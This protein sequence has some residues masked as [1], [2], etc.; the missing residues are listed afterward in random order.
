MLTHLA[1][2]DSHSVCQSRCYQIWL[3]VMFTPCANVGVHKSG[4]LRFPLGVQHRSATTC[5]G[6]S[7][8][9]IFEPQ[10]GRGGC[11]R[12]RS[13]WRGERAG[14]ESGGTFP[15][16]AASSRPD[17][18]Q[19][20]PTHVDMTRHEGIG[21]ARAGCRGAARES[22]VAGEEKGSATQVAAPVLSGAHP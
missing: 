3:S 5:L 16:R 1:L 12:K 19:P 15:F 22:G 7:G 10:R 8:H 17:P 4:S 20:D 6:A 21:C 11:P 13:G 18:N 2:Y 9:A 14:H